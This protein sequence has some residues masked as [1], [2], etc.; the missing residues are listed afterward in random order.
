MYVYS[1]NLYQ[2]AMLIQFTPSQKEI[3]SINI[4]YFDIDLLVLCG[5]IK[6]LDFYFKMYFFGK[7]MVPS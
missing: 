6:F 5:F 3:Y 4:K 7:K 2:N 1:V